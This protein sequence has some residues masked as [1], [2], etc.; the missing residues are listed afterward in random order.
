MRGRDCWKA[1]THA[2]GVD[3]RGAGRAAGLRGKAVEPADGPMGTARSRAGD[4]PWVALRGASLA[5]VRAQELIPCEMRGAGDGGVRGLSPETT[6]RNQGEAAG[7][8]CRERGRT[9]QRGRSVMKT[10]A[11][12]HLSLEETQGRE[13]I[14]RVQKAN[15]GTVAYLPSFGRNMSTLGDRERRAK[16]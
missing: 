3:E 11:P 1:G 14:I 2:R 12:A 10:L 16:R 7:D 9:G 4:F 15:G 6:S 13:C 8:A 5:R